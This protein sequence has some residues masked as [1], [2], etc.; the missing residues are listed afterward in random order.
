ML[1]LLLHMLSFYKP[2]P[3]PRFTEREVLPNYTA[4]DLRL[5]MESRDSGL[6]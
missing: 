5:M 4:K 6:D 3:K 1:E 2:P